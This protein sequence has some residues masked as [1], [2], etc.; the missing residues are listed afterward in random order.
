MQLSAKHFKSS[1]FDI[2][3]WNCYNTVLFHVVVS[4]MQL[5]IIFIGLHMF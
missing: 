5:N 4:G 2:Q 1:S 3:M